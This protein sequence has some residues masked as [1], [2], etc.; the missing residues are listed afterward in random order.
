VESIPNEDY[1]T[2]HLG[3]SVLSVVGHLKNKY[4]YNTV[5]TGLWLKIGAPVNL[6]FSVDFGYTVLNSWQVSFNVTALE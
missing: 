6:T 2:L 3:F 4:Y 1:I 5:G